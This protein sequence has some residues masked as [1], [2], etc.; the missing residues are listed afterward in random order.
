MATAARHDLFSESTDQGSR[1]YWLD[2]NVTFND[3][4]RQQRMLSKQSRCSPA[5]I[6]ACSIQFYAALERLRTRC[7]SAREAQHLTISAS[8]LPHLCKP[9][10]IMRFLNYTDPP[11]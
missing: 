3:I 11:R 1:L 6:V 8:M 2:V 10:I 7:L 5:A 4:I 9:T